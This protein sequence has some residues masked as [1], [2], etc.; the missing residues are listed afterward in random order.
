MYLFDKIDII[1]RNN[2][3]RISIYVIKEISSS[4]LFIFSLITM[5]IW[6]S[7]A[8]RNLEILSNDSVTIAS[9]VFYTILLIPKLSMITIP[10]S[11][12]L[13]I[14]LTLNKFRLDSELIIFGSTGNSN[15]DILLK[16]L[17][18]IGIFFFLIIL[19]L[20]V[21]LVPKSSAEI[22]SKI[23]EIRSSSVNISIL[24][25]KRFI[26]PD[27]NLTVFFKRI[28]GQEIHGLLLHDRSEKNNIKTYVAKKGFLDNKNGNNSIYLYD[29]TMQI[30]NE[31]Q[32][33]I[34]EIDFDKYSIDLKIFDK[35]E[36]KFFYPDE[37]SSTELIKK[38]SSETSNREEF[39]VLH[40]RF[41][42]ALY[43]FSLVFL[44]LV[45]FKIIKKPDDRSGIIISIIITIGIAIKFFEITMESFLV[46]YNNLV[47]INYFL[48]VI[49][50]I[51]IIS[52][53]YKDIHSIK[54]KI[55]N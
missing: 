9:Y 43:I 49:I 25:E 38:I 35:V 22:R 27:N 34:S 5:V 37:R 3:S 28:N 48:P 18:I 23:S 24:K 54:V 7:Q 31:E 6:L 2:M 11:I 36:N 32:Y 55:R 8:L 17:T 10:I 14:I 45:I 20:S 19:F 44:P 30:Y 16:P 42:K 46:T 40:N 21:Y 52:F 50:F 4:F 47:I 1:E 26:T 51:F 12:F 29:G 41:I 39:G 53:L 15:R 13:A 33:K